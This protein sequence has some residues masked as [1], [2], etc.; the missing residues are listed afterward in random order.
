M[1]ISLTPPQIPQNSDKNLRIVYGYLYGMV[2]QLN[3]ALNSL[4]ADNFEPEAQSAIKNAAAG[5]NAAGNSTNSA[6]TSLKSMIIKN[7]EIVKAEMDIIS[8]RL[9]SDYVAQSEFGEYK[10]QVTN[11][12]T[13]SANGVIQQFKSSDQVLLDALNSYKSELSG[14]IKTGILDDGVIGVEITQGDNYRTRFTSSKMAFYQGN[15]EIAY[16]SNNRLYINSAVIKTEL[17]H[18]D[19]FKVIANE[20]EGYTIKYIGG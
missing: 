2:R 1:I 11:D 6:F 19:L 14:Y 8:Q 17:I 16:M 10:K 9:S 13:V 12:I 15:D 7:A 18:N 20:T 3:T 5:I 4:S